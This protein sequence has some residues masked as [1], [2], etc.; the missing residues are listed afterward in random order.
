MKAHNLKDESSLQAYFNQRVQNILERHGKKMVIWEEPMPS[1]QGVVLESWHSG[2]TLLEAVQHGHEALL[3][4]PYYLDQIEPASELYKT[5]PLPADSG[6]TPEQM[7]LALGGEACMWTEHV[8]PETIDSRIWPLVAAIAERFWSPRD[9]NDVADMY[10]RL[11]L[12]SVRLEEFGLKHIS[13]T[14]SML[15]FGAQTTEVGVL[16]EFIQTV[17]PATFDERENAQHPTQFTPLS[18]LIDAA[19]PDPPYG[20]ILSGSVD[21]LLSDA[22]RFVVHRADLEGTFHRWHEMLR[23]FDAMAQKSPL[24]A[25]V[26]PRINE[27]AKLGDIGLDALAFLGSGTAPPPSWKEAKLAMLGEATEPKSL[28]RFV[29]LSPMRELIIGASEA[30]SSRSSNAADWKAR[31]AAETSASAPKSASYR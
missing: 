20:R 23:A 7:E 19:N 25:E 29:V 17:Q 27:L 15:R 13:H 12:M 22:P 8:S 31:V 14:D 11:D 2:A 1:P 28:L 4:A 30:G 26:R 18:H 16:H 3:S 10:R 5:D 9:T 21:A 24:L 6:L